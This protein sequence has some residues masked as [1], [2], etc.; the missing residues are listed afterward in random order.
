MNNSIKIKISGVEYT[1]KQ[2]FRSLMIFENLTGINAFEANNSVNHLLMLFY[3]ILKGC[4]KDFEFEFE[5]FV[6]L[7]DENP[8][9]VELFSNFIQ[10]QAKKQPEEKPS[11]T[12]KKKNK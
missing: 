2:S 3:S 9:S 7:I 6:D 12:P 5:Q 1:I 8:E 11:K 4:N 10:E